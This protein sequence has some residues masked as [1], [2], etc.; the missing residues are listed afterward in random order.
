ML[1]INCGG[2]VTA[3]KMLRFCLQILWRARC[4]WRIWLRHCATSRKVAG[5]FPD[6]VIGIFHVH[7]PSGRTM[8]LGLTQPLTE[9]NTRS[10]SWWGTVGRRVGLTTFPPSG[11]DCLEIWEPQPPV[12]LRAC[13]GLWLDRYTF[14]LLPFGLNWSRLLVA[15]STRFLQLAVKILFRVT[16]AIA[17][18]RTDIARPTGAFL[19]HFVVILAKV[20]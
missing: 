19:Q 4:W 10:I 15:Q 13:P 11:A 2:R 20:W 14:T 6:S 8:A 17:R 7:D 9:M 18:W 1:R 16:V 12:I 3:W 5:S